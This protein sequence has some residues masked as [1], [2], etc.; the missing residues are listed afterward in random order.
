MKHRARTR[1]LAVAT[2]AVLL[3][4]ASSLLGARPG[5]AATTLPSGFQETTLLSGLVNPTAVRFAP[6]GRVFVIEKRGV[7]KIYANL[8]DTNPSSY[9]LRT[10]VHNFW[11][12][13]LL[14]LALDPHLSDAATATRRPYVY[15][16]YTYDAAIGGT[17]PT[18]GTAGT[19][20]DACPNATSTG[21]LASA[22]LSR[23]T[24]ANNGLGTSIVAGSEKVLVNDWC[25][26]YYT[27][28]IGTVAVGSDGMLYASGGEGANADG[29]TPDYGQFG[30]PNNPCG[31]PPGGVGG[32]M[33]PPTA[34]GGAL[35]AQ[36]FRR[37]SGEPTRLSGTVIRVNPDTGDA[38]ADNPNVN[39]TGADANKKRIVAYGL[40]NPFRWTFRPGTNEIWAGDVGQDAWEEIDRITNPLAATTQNFGWPCYEGTGSLSTFQN[41][42]L[43][44]CQSLYTAGTAV[45]PYATYPH[46]ATTADTC[47]LGGSAYTGSSVSGLAFYPGSGGAYPSRYANALFFADYSRQCV[48]AMLA[49]GNGL[50]STTQIETFAR[51][52]DAVDLQSVPQLGGD[53]VW[54]DLNGGT[55]RRLSYGSASSPP[56]AVIATTPSPPSGPLPLTVAF[57]GRGSTDPGGQAITGYSWDFGDGTTGT[58]STISHTYTQRGKFTAKLTVTNA[59]GLTGSST[60]AVVAGAPVPT[61]ATPASTLTYAVGDLVSFSGSAVDAGNQAIPPAQLSWSVVIHHCATLSSCH[62]HPDVFSAVGVASGQF[63]APDHDY[64]S[65][66]ELVLT[67]K[68]SLGLTGSTSVTIYPKTTTLTV[69]SN[70]PGLTLSAGSVTGTTPFTK[71]AVTNSQV[72]LTAPPSQTLGSTSY[73]FGSWSDG[74]AA[75]H[76][77]TAAAAATYTATYSQSSLITVPPPSATAWQLNGNASMVGTALQLTPNATSQR[78]SAFYPTAV[79]STNLTVDFDATLTGGGTTGADGLTFTLAN[80]TAGPTALGALGGGLG[81]AGINGTA[82][83]LDTYKNWNST[84]PSNNFAG[85]ATGYATGNTDS[86]T[87]AA[88][89]TTVPNLRTGTHHLTITTTNGTITVKIDGT[90]YL[91]KAVTLPPTVLVG[92][93]AGTGDTTDA[94][95]ATNVTI[96]AR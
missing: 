93:T 95:T 29:N 57:D 88:T 72:T 77:V 27:H 5:A 18:W 73:S 74:G 13:G 39:V 31:D 83:A 85:I 51:G 49:G 78:G 55:V 28:S 38:A 68:D 54:V 43:T 46:Q 82:I 34:E 21:C 50:P 80:P 91:T 76:T 40:R 64:P 3:A 35:R 48:Y 16:L 26:Q 32:S 36:S 70:P 63:T 42:G 44:L 86:L 66:L 61:I 53:L 52:T 14:G 22:R 12:R 96:T 8:A 58:G 17:A 87:W 90:Q 2:T 6:D 65:Y 94:H 92:F 59:S 15:L 69:A 1:W 84:D 25:I 4:G 79:P 56:S 45:A 7:L 33:T 23:L 89:N 67:A 47:A 81:Y 71:T 19:D 24:V 11:D 41:L 9:D 60:V 37:P 30:S 75:T 62:T 20:T 10:A